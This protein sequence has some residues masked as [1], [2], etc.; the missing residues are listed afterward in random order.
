MSSDYTYEQAMAWKGEKT[1]KTFRIGVYKLYTEDW[2]VEAE[3]KMEALA[4]LELGEGQ[5]VS[6][7]HDSIE[8]CN[9]IAHEYG[10]STE[11]L[12]DQLTKAEIDEW[13]G[14]KRWPFEDK[15]GDYLEGI[16]GIVEEEA[17][18]YV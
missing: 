12:E 7:D 9:E 4:K 10:M 13:S 16:A 18:D 8:S 2:I 11:D 1:M 3:T 6:K 17:I 15:Q 14:G 5:D